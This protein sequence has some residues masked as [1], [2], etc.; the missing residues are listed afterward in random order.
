MNKAKTS[1]TFTL[2][3]RQQ[4]ILADLLK[5]GNYKLYKAEHA[6]IAAQIPD[7]RI[8]IYTSGKC[9][10]Q[11]KGATDFVTYVLEPTVIGTAT[12]GYED[13]IN[14]DVSA[15]HLGVD[16]SGKG[17]LFGPLVVAGAYVDEELYKKFQDLNVR[18]SK[19]F[20]SDAKVLELG[21]QLR[22]LLGDRY[23]IVRM[24]P[25]A[26]NKLYLQM[27]NVNRILAWAHAR[28][29]ENLLTVMPDCPRAISDQF[30]S[31]SLVE[32]ALMSR[33]KRVE[34]VQK[35]RAESDLAVA[36]ASILAREEFLRSLKQIG[37]KYKIKAPKGASAQVKTVALGLLK[38][39]GPDVLIETVKCHFK[40]T[41]E[42][43]AEA[44]LN[45]DALGEYAPVLAR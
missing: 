28:V 6:R 25:K 37:D 4:V 43:L 10:V 16:E 30:G 39:H 9:L 14:P 26:Y 3:E 22:G 42:V 40:T 38:Q 24:G 32:R 35:H 8:I 44:G 12:V 2:S 21:K 11:G 15:P 45:R 1:F 36:A 41:A 33:G 27:R 20:T 31:K 23:N 34:L 7:C 29:I 13:V 5:H 19:L 18:D 17:D